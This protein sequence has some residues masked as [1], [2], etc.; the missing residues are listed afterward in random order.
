MRK[1]LNII[2]INILSLV[3]LPFFALSV[4]FSMLSSA[5]K[6]VGTFLALA[7]AGCIGYL[8]LPLVPTSLF[9]WVEMIVTFVAFLV[10]FGILF[11]IIA[12]LFS[13]MGATVAL[14]Y[15]AGSFVLESLQSITYRVYMV[16]FGIC[17]SKYQ[18]LSIN[19][20]KV[21]NAVI[22]P[23]FSLLKGCSRLIVI[24]I[25]FAFPASIVAGV[26]IVVLTLMNLSK[27]VS[28]SLGLSLFAFLKKY[29]AP[30]LILSIVVYVY[31]IGLIVYLI[32]QFGIEMRR[33]AKELYI[34]T[35]TLSS[36]LGGMMDSEIHLTIG[37]EAE[38]TKDYEKKL[39]I[40]QD[41]MEH[42]DEL[43]ARIEKVLDQKEDPVLQNAWTK[44]MNTLSYIVTA[45]TGKEL[46]IDEFKSYF[47]QIDT[48]DRQRKNLIKMTEKV[49]EQL[50]DPSG[51]STFFVG[52]DS[53]EK[54]D[55]RYN[56]LCKAF[57]PDQSAGDTETFQKMK[58]EYEALKANFVQPPQ[59]G[60]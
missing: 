52:C 4:I 22:C 36:E 50:K 49:E 1:L 41:H 14:F 33:W 15:A 48:L 28:A 29:E 43:S 60:D 31:F 51:T 56:S 54:L 18:E 25:P 10:V 3:A 9:G 44:Y 19:G 38:N 6:K 55:K 5:Y 26:G 2:V 45:C 57:H 58:D 46:P 8:L 13:L 30:S 21:Q 24:I 40:L 23:F 47:A 32:I 27:T 59:V 16:L 34:D 12:F 37:E 35:S 42:F 11:V 17:E 7:F 39:D 20:K 53:L